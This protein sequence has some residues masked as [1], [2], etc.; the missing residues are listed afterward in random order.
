MTLRAGWPRPSTWILG[1]QAYDA[2]ML[3]PNELDDET[4][5]LVMEAVQIGTQHGLNIA[6]KRIRG[7]FEIEPLSWERV[8]R[9]LHEKDLWRTNMLERDEF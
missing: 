1:K 7:D 3:D 6:E 4:V 8:Q 2:R 9:A 5:A